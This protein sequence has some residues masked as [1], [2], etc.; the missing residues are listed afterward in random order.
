MT[1]IELIRELAY[2]DPHKEVVAYICDKE[3]GEIDG[4]VEKRYDD[5]V[6]IEVK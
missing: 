1:V 4:V 5:E 3:I 6:R 2:C